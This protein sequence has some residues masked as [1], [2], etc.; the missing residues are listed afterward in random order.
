M[1]IFRDK[2]IFLSD[3]NLPAL[4]VELHLPWQRHIGVAGIR[5]HFVASASSLYIL[6]VIMKNRCFQRKVSETSVA[7][8]E[9]LGLTWRTLLV[10][11]LEVA[12]T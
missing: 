8:F 4:L 7:S 6:H 1:H 2:I 12:S 5:H 10:Q 9:A 3:L 11:V